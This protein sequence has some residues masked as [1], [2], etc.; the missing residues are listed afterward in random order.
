MELKRTS[1]YE[2]HKA[3]GARFTGFAGFEL[4]VSYS[5]VIE[6]HLAVRSRV[7]LFDVSHMGEFEL[8]GPGALGAVQLV[9][10]NDASVIGE[11]RAQYTL[12]CNERG[13][14]IDDVVLY[15]FSKERFI[16]C[17]NGANTEKVSK[18]LGK[19]LGGLKGVEL[20][21]LSN[22][23]A[24]LALQGPGSAEVLREVTDFDLTSLRY[25]GF[26]EGGV[27][28]SSAEPSP[29]VSALISRTGYT[30]EDGF[31]LYVAPGDA[32]PLWA[33]LME[34][35]APFGITACGLGARDT[36]RIEMG[37]PLYG[38]EL[39]ED[40]SPLEAGLSRFVALDKDP[41]FIGSEALTEQAEQ[42]EEAGGGLK[43]TLVGLA[44]RGPGIPREGYPVLKDG[45]E[46][47]SVTSGTFSPTLKR[48]VAMAYV[49]PSLGEAGTELEVGIR[50]RNV[51]VV[52]TERPFFKKNDGLKKT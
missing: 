25:Y 16:F 27:K 18:W 34:A 24:Q 9:T 20:R 40:T 23:Y 29:E 46:V 41:P 3:L 12:I 32:P 45:S 38:N 47:G 42:G 10:T 49:E 4:P 36:L 13:G 2:T 7:G 52:V 26:I 15:C 22:G 44:T 43:K 6:E 51:R 48:P 21:D 37:F 39:S 33:S 30:G 1:L 19:N 5:S 28:L 31:E 8:R 14:V 50:G 11:G 17:V 35:G